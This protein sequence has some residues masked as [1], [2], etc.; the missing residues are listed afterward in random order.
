MNN[1]TPNFDVSVCIANF[2]GIHLI[3][4]C[5]ASVFSQQ[6]NAIFEIIVHDDA[7][8]DNSAN[9]IESKY[10]QVKLI[11]S[12][13]NVG[14]CISNNR[15]V[16]KARGAY[17]LLL[18]ND[19]T[20]FPDAL[21]SLYAH[22]KQCG[23]AL[24]GLPQFNAETGEFIDAGSSLD[25][26]FNPVPNAIAQRPGPV[27]MIIGA[28][29][30]I[31]QKIWLETGGFPP[32][33]H[34]LAEDM[35]LC[36]AARLKGY[37]SIVLH[38]SGFKHHVGQSLGGGKLLNRQLKTTLSR[39]ISSERN[40]TFVMVTTCPTVLLCLIFPIHC[41]FLA[42]EGLILSL[43]KGTPRLLREIYLHAILETWINRRSLLALRRKTLSRKKISI[44]AYLSPFQVV[45][46][47]AR[48]LI[49]Y[50]FPEISSGGG[51]RP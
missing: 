40:K 8:T 50:G 33:F 10:P 17:I 26:F 6:T 32:L 15:M 37:P 13:E 2:N 24:L 38:T 4:P 14:F 35:Y 19:A 18:N 9:Y 44:N 22:S 25:L 1:Q 20:L 16:A 41:T 12:A 36:C 29:L 39:R 49:R 5:L 51:P 30:W 34:T 47:K 46:H 45:P 7:S 27:G 23:N 28:C 21:E 31:P 3:D 42:V 43:I 48:M 11:R